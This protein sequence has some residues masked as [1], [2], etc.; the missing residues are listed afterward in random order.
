MSYWLEVALRHRL[1]VD[2][3]RFDGEL[4]QEYEVR[5]EASKDPEEDP[6]VV[7]Q[8]SF[9]V[10]KLGLALD[11][12]LDALDACDSIDQDVH[13]LATAALDPDTGQL[14]D[15]LVEAFD[16]P[17]G[18]LLL[19]RRLEIDEAHRGQQLGLVVLDRIIDA[20]GSGLV[21]CLPALDGID[22]SSAVTS[23]F[24][25]YL[26]RLGF[27]PIGSGSTM[28]LSAGFQRPTVSLVPR[29]GSANDN[30]R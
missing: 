19:L 17:L 1:A 8:A 23:K 30:S 22:P 24:R 2:A 18:D 12:E 3:E 5:I 13:D 29:G 9:C 10:V 27:S 11:A 14:R 16:A 28:A 15:D 6:V 21:V 26:A 20:F 7:G 4:V 25:G